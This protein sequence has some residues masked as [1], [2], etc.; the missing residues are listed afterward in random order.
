ME[1]E[2]FDVWIQFGGKVKFLKSLCRK[3]RLLGCWSFS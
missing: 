2:F 1:E 3:T